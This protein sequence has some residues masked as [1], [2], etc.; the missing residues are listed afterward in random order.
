MSGRKQGRT[1]LT[2]TVGLYVC[3][4]GIK[5]GTCISNSGHYPNLTTTFSVYSRTASV[6]ASR[7]NYS[8]ISVSDLTLATRISDTNITALRQAMGWLL[9]YNS[10]GIP[11]TSSIAQL[12]WS[13]PIQVDNDLW[14]MESYQVFKSILAFPFWHF[15]PNN[16]GNS[17]L[18]TNEVVS[19]LPEEFYTTAAI[20]SSNVRIE[21]NKGMF[22]AFVVLEGSVLV[23]VWLVLLTT[24]GVAKRLPYISSYPVLDFSFKTQFEYWDSRGDGEDVRRSPPNNSSDSTVRSR[25]SRLRVRLRSSEIVDTN[26]GDRGKTCE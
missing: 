19:N 5:E 15:N 11:A 14:S 3:P 22:V 24:W 10:A 25:A 13:S 7:S 17:G 12:F 18:K 1:Y 2:P 23:F 8:I 26:C 16:Y 21:V 9:D 6:I 20:V 4:D